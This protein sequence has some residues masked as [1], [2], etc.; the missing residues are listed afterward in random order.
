MFK[1]YKKLIRD[2]FM[3]SKVLSSSYIGMESYIYILGVE[4][5]IV[6]VFLFLM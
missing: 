6:E 5:D 3:V 2:D 1:D 4:V